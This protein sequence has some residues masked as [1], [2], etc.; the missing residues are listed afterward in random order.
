MLITVENQKK[1]MYF[2]LELEM[3]YKERK[4]KN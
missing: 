2:S 4:K 1:K 3:K